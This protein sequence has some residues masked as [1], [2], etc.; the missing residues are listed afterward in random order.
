MQETFHKCWVPPA[1]LTGLRCFG[2]Q[3]TENN[4]SHLK[5]T[6][7]SMVERHRQ[8]SKLKGGDAP[9][10]IRDLNYWKA[11]KSMGSI[12]ST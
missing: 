5:Y 4:S 2:L 3:A 12:W 7:K 9:G 11:K 8:I 6:G 1:F 10:L